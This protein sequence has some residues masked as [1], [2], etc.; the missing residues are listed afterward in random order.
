[1]NKSCII[2]YHYY[3]ISHLLQSIKHNFDYLLILLFQLRILNFVPAWRIPIIWNFD[4]ALDAE[5]CPPVVG[6]QACLNIKFVCQCCHD[7]V[8]R[9]KK[10]ESRLSI[11]QL[12]CNYGNCKQKRPLLSFRFL[13]TS[14]TSISNYSVHI[15]LYTVHSSVHG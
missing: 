8:C 1:M 13:M 4:A 15:A 7:L 10:T 2:E 3:Y 6:I 9:R 14:G 11:L 5:G 12:H